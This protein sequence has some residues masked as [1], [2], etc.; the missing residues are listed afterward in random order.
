VGARGGEPALLDVGAVSFVKA[1]R[2]ILRLRR[3]EAH[4]RCCRRRQPLLE[5][6]G[7]EA[8]ELQEIVWPEQVGRGREEPGEGDQ[9]LG[10][11]LA[12]DQIEDGDRSTSE[13]LVASHERGEGPEHGELDAAREAGFASA[14]DDHRSALEAVSDRRRGGDADVGEPACHELPLEQRPELVD[15]ERVE[16]HGV[17][18]VRRGSRF[19][20]EKKAQDARGVPHVG[21]VSAG[22]P[23]HGLR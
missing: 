5:I 14:L 11:R 6:G 4:P 22:A 16:E 17:D 13:G 21:H 2:E 19:D 15:L 23:L 20:P 12:S 10:R 18:L 1:P 8:R 7:H 9:H 3:I